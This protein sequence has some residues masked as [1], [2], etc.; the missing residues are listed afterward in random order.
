MS[1]NSFNEYEIRRKATEN[2]G[3]SKLRYEAMKA[4]FQLSRC[5]HAKNN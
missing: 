4:A 2:R 3:A 5:R 1:R